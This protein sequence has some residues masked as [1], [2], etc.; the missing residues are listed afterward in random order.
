[1]ATAATAGGGGITR[2]LDSNLTLFSAAEI[3]VVRCV[4]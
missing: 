1:M 2:T 3:R 4:R